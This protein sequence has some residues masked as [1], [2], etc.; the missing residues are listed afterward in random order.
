MPEIE[1]PWLEEREAAGVVEGLAAASLV[2]FP[3]AVELT[4]TVVGDVAVT[5]EVEVTV[6]GSSRV[7]EV[8]SAVVSAVVSAVDSVVGVALAEGDQQERYDL[9]VA[10][11]SVPVY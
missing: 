7:E 4:T 2:W 10:L 8:D 3:A 1:A 6:V 5:T 9:L 11:V